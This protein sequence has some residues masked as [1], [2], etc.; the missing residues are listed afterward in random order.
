[1]RTFLLAGALLLVLA[2]GCGGSGGSDDG[3]TT[4]SG[5][6]QPRETQE[7]RDA[8]V[9]AAV[10]RQLVTEDHT[11]GSAK[12]PFE[13]VYVLDGAVPGAADP[14]AAGGE[15]ASRQRFP[16]ETKAA[17]LADLADLPPVTFVERRSAVVEGT[18]GGESPGRVANDGALVTL[19]PIE[20]E[21]EEVE[22]ESS[23]WINGLAGTWRTYAV[24]LEEGRWRVTETRGPISIS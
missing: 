18:D 16:E 4:V 19:G 17:I 7:T 11:F 20:G 14:E 15:A 6:G 3:A 2:A 23:L 13:V 1:M 10:I 22:V 24:E 8:E 9:Y 21:G 5:S 12:P